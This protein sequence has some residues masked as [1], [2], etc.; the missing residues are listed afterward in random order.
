MCHPFQ[1]FASEIVLRFLVK[2]FCRV[3]PLYHRVARVTAI[4][5]VRL[6]V[7][8]VGSCLLAAVRRW[9]RM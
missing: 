4:A 7:M 1:T 9:K 8:C 6:A 2:F 3:R 5:V